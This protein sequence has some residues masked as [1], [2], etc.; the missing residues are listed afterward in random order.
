MTCMKITESQNGQIYPEDTFSH[1]AAHL[2]WLRNKIVI[3]FCCF[4]GKKQRDVFVKQKCNSPLLNFL[5]I[6][7]VVKRSRSLVHINIAHMTNLNIST[8]KMCFQINLM[9]YHEHQSNSFI[10]YNQ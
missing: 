8:P 1:G 2:F 7:K 9:P 4:F 3:W 10:S 6:S 5:T